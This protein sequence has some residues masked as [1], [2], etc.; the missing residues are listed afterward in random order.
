M[1]SGCVNVNMHM[2]KTSVKTAINVSYSCHCVHM[3]E[4]NLIFTLNLSIPLISI[5]NPILSGIFLQVNW[6]N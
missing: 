2:T 3:N 1:I 5:R 4:N 6:T